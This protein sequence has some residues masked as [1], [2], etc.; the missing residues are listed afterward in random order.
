MIQSAAKVLA[1]RYQPLFGDDA[2]D[3]ALLM[4]RHAGASYAPADAASLARCGEIIARL[5]DAHGAVAPGFAH[6]SSALIWWRIA[7]SGLRAGR[8]GIGDV[9]R[10]RPTFATLA[11]AHTPAAVRDAAIGIARRIGRRSLSPL[12]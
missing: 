11:A 4:S 10:A 5:L 2:M 9:A 1:A 8:Y 3:A 6:A 7:R 12:W